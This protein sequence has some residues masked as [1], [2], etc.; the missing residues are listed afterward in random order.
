[1]ASP[2]SVVD[3][4]NDELAPTSA[5]QSFPAQ[6]STTV[7]TATVVAVPVISPEVAV[8]QSTSEVW[9]HF[10]QGKVNNA[11]NRC[12]AKIKTQPDRSTSNMRGHLKDKHGIKLESAKSTA[13]PVTAG[14]R[15]ALTNYF[16]AAPSSSSSSPSGPTPPT[17]QKRKRYVLMLLRLAV[18]M[19][20]S[21]RSIAE[22]EVLGEFMLEELAFA[23]P[24]RM[25]LSR[26]LPQ[27]YGHLV[28]D[29]KQRL[30]TAESVSVTTDSTF[31]A[32]HQ[33][34]YICITGHWI[35]A[36][37][38]LRHCVLAVF[39]ASQQE[40]GDWIAERL[41]VVLED[42]LCLSSKL[43]CIVTDEGKNFLSA[44][45]TLTDMEVLRESLR[46]ACHRIQLTV[47]RAL[48]SSEC[49]MLMGALKKA[50]TIVLQFKNGWMSRKR[51]VLKK[52]QDQYVAELREEVAK[53]NAGIVLHTTREKREQAAKKIQL[54]K[55]AERDLELQREEVA[56][57]G[58]EKAQVED[59]VR[60]LS[61]VD[62]KAHT[63]SDDEDDNTGQSREE[64][65]EDAVV[66]PNIV[67]LAEE[68]EEL[69]AVIAHIT[70]K[71]A[72][73]AVAATRWLTWVEVAERTMMWKG[74]LMK[75]LDE[76]AADG[77]FKKKKK[78]QE[79]I[80]ASI[81]SMRISDEEAVIL[82]QFRKFG[83]TINKLL[84][85]LEGDDHTTIGRLLYVRSELL[86][87]FERGAAAVDSLHPVITTFCKKAV[88]NCI[89]KFNNSIDRP[90]L[91]G[92]AL[93]PRHHNLKFLP[94]SD[95][96]LCADALS[97]A[98]HA[99]K[100]EQNDDSPIREPLPKRVRRSEVQEFDFDNSQNKDKSTRA[101]DELTRFAELPDQEDADPLG[102]WKLHASAFPI[103]STLAR[104][105]LAIPAS[106]ASSERLFSQLKLT[107]TPARRNM[108]PDT[109]CMLLFVEA[110]HR[111]YRRVL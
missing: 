85:T 105:Y 80:S 13:V 26:L 101:K 96:I 107:A 14:D 57:Q 34:P 77:S 3:L 5:L 81:A 103:L 66:N 61:L 37:W 12:G 88:E 75:A 97:S 47:K 104:R 90:A 94:R 68:K 11:C 63:E 7:V 70:R 10:T 92:A 72:L 41:R 21:F 71:R 111:W 110:H 40:T 74:P 69:M 43:H 44:V 50:Q 76:I 53:L 109:L 55:A 17:A 54:L 46:C 93:D 16:S 91:I 1:M 108:S 52:F 30:S 100:I 22:S 78:N 15:G 73:I 48:M 82:D 19:N 79:D 87:Y 9:K 24:S 84:K 42:Q 106:S 95:Q 27:Y 51:D 25:A 6:L 67:E 33:T 83:A 86:A 58:R 98:Y 89:I 56:A 64:K 8:N 4:R 2:P 20:A 99:M 18:E 102:W 31:L 39:E 60:Q 35:D 59:E 65:G 45:Q 62:E 38:E 23:M 49:A 28:A 32:L 36:H 29:L